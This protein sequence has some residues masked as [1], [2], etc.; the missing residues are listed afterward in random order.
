M[1]GCASLPTGMDPGSG[2]S[3]AAATSPSWL[4]PQIFSLLAPAMLRSARRLSA[5]DGV[6]LQPVPFSHIGAFRSQN[7][8]V[9]SQEVGPSSWERG[10]RAAKLPARGSAPPASGHLTPVM[11]DQHA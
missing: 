8:M 7:V 3:G 1:P 6:C 11:E 4:Q 5:L 2:G 10:R 9:R